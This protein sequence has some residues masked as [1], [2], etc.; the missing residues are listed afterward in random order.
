MTFKLKK[1]PI[2][3]EE[4][5]RY[6]ECY[7]SIIVDGYDG[8]ILKELL[9]TIEDSGIDLK[10][11]RVDVKD[12]YDGY[13]ITLNFTGR[14]I[15]DHFDERMND[16]NNKMAQFKKEESNYNIWYDDN[17]E[18]IEAEIHRKLEVEHKKILK[19][20]K[21]AEKAVTKHKKALEKFGITV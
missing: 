1:I 17:K 11:V 18:K 21:A 7:N 3:P 4:P 15:E 2:E 5:I 19:E 16:Y 20:M 6:N 8:A 10:D 14:E 13:D 12:D 9:I